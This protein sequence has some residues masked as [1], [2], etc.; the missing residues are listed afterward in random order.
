MSKRMPAL[1]AGLIFLAGAAVA[2][3]RLMVGFPIVIA[4]ASIGQTA[5]F[6][7]FVICAGLS[8]FFFNAAMARNS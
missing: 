2:L 3:Y 5:S 7:G 4:G 1:V 6:L 8:F